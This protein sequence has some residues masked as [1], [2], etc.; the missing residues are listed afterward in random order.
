[1]F[2]SLLGIKANVVRANADAVLPGRRLT[3]GVATLSSTNATTGAAHQD[4]VLLARTLLLQGT[5]GAGRDSGR[6]VAGTGQEIVAQGRAKGSRDTLDLERLFVRV[7][8]GRLTIVS[9]LFV[10]VARSRKH[11]TNGA[12]CKKK[13]RFLCDGKADETQDSCSKTHAR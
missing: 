9:K 5:H 10:A 11:I 12:S 4:T 8:F 6:H 7:T 3:G 13:T 2:T 1:M